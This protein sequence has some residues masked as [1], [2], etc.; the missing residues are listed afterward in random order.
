MQEDSEARASL[1]PVQKMEASLPGAEL[2]ALLHAV[3][4]QVNV[5]A[6]RASGSDL[7]DR[8]QSQ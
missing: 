8:C 4:L 2:T 5:K 3:S 7:R 6:N 1:I